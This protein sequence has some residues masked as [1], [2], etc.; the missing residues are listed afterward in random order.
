MGE[1]AL[2]LIFA[3][4]LVFAPGVGSNGANE[5]A[6]HE[7]DAAEVATTAPDTASHRTRERDPRPDS[8]LEAVEQRR[9]VEAHLDDWPER[10]YF[11]GGQR[12]ER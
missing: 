8:C 1:A 12:C 4:M 11:V 9:Q 2:A 10:T 3:G 6:G 7:T 5:P